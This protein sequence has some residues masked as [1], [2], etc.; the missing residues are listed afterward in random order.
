MIE[1]YLLLC[2][3]YIHF[4]KQLYIF[5]LHL[6]SMDCIC[7]WKL[8]RWTNVDTFGYQADTA[9]HR[10]VPQLLC[11]V[12]VIRP[13]RP[14]LLLITS[15]SSQCVR[16]RQ[17]DSHQ[18]LFLATIRRLFSDSLTNEWM[19]CVGHRRRTSNATPQVCAAQYNRHDD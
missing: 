15:N 12:A 7:T 14:M 13:S 17:S 8:R 11:H 6:L 2:I 18:Q 3:L 16:W 19:A 1:I 9:H 5:Y 4:F 10:Y